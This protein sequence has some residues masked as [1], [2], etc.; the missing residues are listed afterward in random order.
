MTVRIIPRTSAATV[1]GVAV[2]IS[3]L[4]LGGVPRGTAL[5][6]A[7]RD[8]FSDTD[9]VDTMNR[10]DLMNQLAEQGFESVFVTP[11]GGWPGDDF[12]RALIDHVLGWASDRGWLPDQIGVLG[13]DEGARAALLGAAEHELGGAVSVPRA[14]KQLLT[15]A[16]ALRTPWLGVVGTG[17]AAELDHQLAAFR[18]RLRV[19]SSAHTAVVGYRGVD[20]C[21]SDSTEPVVHAAAFDSWQRTVEWLNIHVAPR[22]TP[23]ALAWQRS[24]AAQSLTD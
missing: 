18:D 8:P 24:R 11:A 3:E 23:L 1:A 2:E 9:A 21:L 20:H 10:V 19:E 7:S 6:V 4:L 14:G 22:P 5:I 13:Y 17:S 15:P 16:A 12:G